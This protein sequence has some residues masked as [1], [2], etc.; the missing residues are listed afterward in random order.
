MRAGV[1]V[2]CCCCALLWRRI[3]YSLPEEVCLLAHPPCPAGAAL[4]GVH[5][6]HGPQSVGRSRPRL[7]ND[8][9][10]SNAP[11]GTAGALSHKLRAPPL[12]PAHAPP[13]SHTLPP[14]FESFPG[15]GNLY[16]ECILP[17]SSTA[18]FHVS[19]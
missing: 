13:V 10:G 11:L 4:P 6:N 19:S 15:S 12:M 14:A 2:L 16:I 7:S 5:R 1:A 3:V 9:R 18:P 8:T 17:P